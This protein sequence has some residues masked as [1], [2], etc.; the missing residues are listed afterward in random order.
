M[1]TYLHFCACIFFP[2][3]RNIMNEF[4]AR[5]SSRKIQAIFKSRMEKG[6]RC[7]GS[8]PYGYR[9]DPEDKQHLIVDEETWQ[10]A[11]RLKRT[12]RKPSYPD[13]PSNPLT[14]LLYCA[15]CGHKLTH[16][17]PSP[18][19]KK[20]FDADDAYLCG[21]YRHLTRDCTMHFIKTSTVEKLVLTAIRGVS[22]YVRE[23]EK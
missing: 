21:G 22:A 15:D 14:G 2:H 1:L 20:V 7:S 8:V 9:R 19:E 13:R 11:H 5:D 3:T 16:H 12:I 4:Y 18:T 23:D 10:L 6:L 17:Q